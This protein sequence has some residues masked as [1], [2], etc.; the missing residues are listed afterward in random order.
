MHAT[1]A[2]ATHPGPDPALVEYALTLIARQH[3]G[4]PAAVQSAQQRLREWRAFDP[5]HE[6]AWRAAD[7]LWSSAD[8]T[9]W[10]APMPLPPSAAQRRKR[11]RALALGA[12]AALSLGGLTLHLHLQRPL[13]EAVLISAGDRLLDRALPDGSRVSLD[14]HSSAQVAYYRDRRVVRLDRGSAYFDVQKEPGQPF[15]VETPA[16]TVRVLGTGFEVRLAEG[17]M[18]VAVA[19]GRVEVCPASGNDRDPAAACPATQAVRLSPGQRL[20]VRDG[21]STNAGWLRAEDVG[22]WRQGWLVFDDT[23]LPQVLQRWNDYLPRPLQLASA[24][25]LQSL[26]LTG[27]FP[28]AEP[29]VFLETLPQVLPVRVIQNGDDVVIDTQAR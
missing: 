1:A 13:N 14:V 11:G 21:T 27:S 15:V 20:A 19:H 8:P 25:D 4:D 6:T 3:G 26:R 2:D 12:V 28:L 17:A 18:S 10:G 29:Q 7:R 16:G 23:P 9:G 5:R 22:A 24:S